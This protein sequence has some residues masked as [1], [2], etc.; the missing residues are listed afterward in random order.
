M[1]KRVLECSDVSQCIHT[2]RT[3]WTGAVSKDVSITLSSCHVP[4]CLSHWREGG[5]GTDI[6][7]V[8]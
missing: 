7:E 1:T 5:T 2:D 8:G 4:K 6:E 3:S